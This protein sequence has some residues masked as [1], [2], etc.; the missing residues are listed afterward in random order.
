[1]EREKDQNQERRHSTQ[2]AGLRGHLIK[3]IFSGNQISLSISGRSG[4]DRGEGCHP[5]LPAPVSPRNWPKSPSLHWV[6][7]PAHAVNS[8]PRSGSPSLSASHTETCS[9]PRAQST[10]PSPCTVCSSCPQRLDCLRPIC[11]MTSCTR[12]GHRGVSGQR[13]ILRQ[14]GKFCPTENWSPILR[15]SS[16]TATQLGKKVLHQAHTRRFWNVGPHTA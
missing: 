4:S 7:F 14:K 8:V 2:L 15:Q 12:T 9:P 11:G 16:T 13:G 6:W 3:L 1:M 5:A 10:C